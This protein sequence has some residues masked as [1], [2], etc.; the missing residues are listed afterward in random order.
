VRNGDGQTAAD[1]GIRDAGI[2]V[3]TFGE[4]MIRIERNLATAIKS[5]YMSPYIAQ[6]VKFT[7]PMG[8]S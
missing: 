8:A 2:G 6:V 1:V 3:E 5:R 4:V 7:V